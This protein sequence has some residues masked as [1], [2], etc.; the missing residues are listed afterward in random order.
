[1]ADFKAWPGRLPDWSVES[2]VTAR[3][4]L[5]AIMLNDCICFP[6]NEPPALVVP[7]ER[8]AAKGV[9]CLLQGLGFAGFG[10]LIIAPNRDWCICK[11]TN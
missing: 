11:K 3:A 1:M 5:G 2:R 9:L 8:D 7:A 10:P 4:M 6:A